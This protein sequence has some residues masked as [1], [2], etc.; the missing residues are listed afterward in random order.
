MKDLFTENR[1]ET[2]L[3]AAVILAAIA[4]RLYNV[5]GA[6]FDFNPLRQALG[7]FVARN[8]A[9]TPDAMFFLP[10]VDNMGPS[11][12]YFMFELPLLPYVT[13]FLIKVLGVQNWVFRVIP[14]VFFVTSAVYFYKLAAIVLDKRA[15]LTALLI[16]SF[17]PMSILMGRVFQPESFMMM[18]MMFLVYHFMKWLDAEKPRDLFFATAGLTLFVLLK[19]TN[20][21]I[22]LF[23]GAICLIYGK[24]RSIVRAIGPAAVVLAVNV[25]WWLVYPADIRMMF[26][27]EYTVDA[28]AQVFGVSH[29]AAMLKEYT[30]S[31]SYW[32]LAVKQCAWVVFS[33]MVF[34]LLLGGVFSGLKGRAYLFLIS[35]IGSALVFIAAVPDAAVQDYYKLHLVPAGSMLAAVFYLKLYDFIPSSRGGKKLFASFVITIS[36]ITIFAAVYPIVRYKPVFQ[37]QEMLGRKVRDISLKEDLIIASFGPDPMLLFY[38]DRKGWAQYLLSGKD[39]IR[40]LEEKRKEGA[41]YFVCGNLEELSSVGEFERYLMRKYKLLIKESPE[42]GEPEGYTIEHMAWRVLKN[43]NATWASDIRRKFERKSYGMAVFD[44]TDRAI[45]TGD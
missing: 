21:Y 23:L 4:V 1:R 28:G 10:Q 31:L 11:P 43:I 19:I 25:W 17:A 38:C 40:L 16:Y 36:V 34:I 27:N 22:F 32:S 37:A 41:K 7:A 13:S 18:A 5:N 3:V 39:Q 14:I 26:P 8:F 33:P 24:Q 35:W 15:S 42:S 2:I 12:G 45:L 20:L 30:C 6:L 44:L 29:M 9:F